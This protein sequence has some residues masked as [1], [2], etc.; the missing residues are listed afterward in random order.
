MLADIAWCGRPENPARQDRGEDRPSDR[1]IALTRIMSRE[2]IVMSP[3]AIAILAVGMSVDA[4]IAS[5]G[6]GAGAA[7]PSWADALKTGAVFGAVETLTPLLGWLMGVVASQ[8]VQEIDH[9]I[10]FV[11]LG[12]VGGRMAL[13][14]FQRDAE[15][16]AAANR[17]LATLLATAVGTSIDAMAV[18]VSLAFLQV[19]IVVIALAIG[20]ATT[21]MS[22]GG[23]LAG[24]FLGARFGR[25]AEIAGG[26]ALIGLGASILHDHL[27]A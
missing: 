17:S 27:T 26:L 12:G 4:L 10:A 13:H 18:G 15:A 14:A 24:R 16:P 8:Y 20:A 7:R 25:Y 6:R 1:P 9:W 3:L 5:I 19:N 22:T 23:I 11:L 21:L 2:I